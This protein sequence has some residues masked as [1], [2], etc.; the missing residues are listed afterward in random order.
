MGHCAQCLLIFTAFGCWKLSAT[1]PSHSPQGIPIM[2][3]RR[4]SKGG[5]RPHSHHALLWFYFPQVLS[6]PTLLTSQSTDT[7]VFLVV[8]ILA[9]KS[10]LK[11]Y[12]M[13]RILRIIV[14]DATI[15]FLVIFTSHFVF[16]MTLLLARVSTSTIGNRSDAETSPDESPTLTSHVSSWFQTNHEQCSPFPA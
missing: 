5:N 14:Q 2:C 1:T 4:T 15:Y 8:V 3:S 16:W 11:G 6:H 7:S 12:K 10:G 9:A 13:P